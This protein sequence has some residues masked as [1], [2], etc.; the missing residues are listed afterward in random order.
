[1]SIIVYSPLKGRLVPIESVPDVVF[2]E[3]MLG[4]GVAI[5]PEEGVAVVPVTGM[6]TALPASGHAFGM[7]LAMGIEM[8]VH[9][10]LDTV[11][12]DGKGFKL[13]AS[14]DQSVQAGQKVIEFS[15]QEILNAGKQ[16][17]S[18]VVVL[19]AQI[20][21]IAKDTVELGEPLFEVIGDGI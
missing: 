4:D 7:D 14:K 13:L 12:M 1:M 5:I 20:K 10:G 21:P 8:L 19:G 15:I 2:A 3:K 6:I 17:V 9:I 11:D 18:P 16:I